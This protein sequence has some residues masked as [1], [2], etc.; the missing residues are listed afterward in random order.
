MIRRETRKRISAVSTLQPSSARLIPSTLLMIIDRLSENTNL[1]PWSGP[2]QDKHAYVHRSSTRLLCW[3]SF[4]HQPPPGPGAASAIASFPGSP[5][6][7]TPKARASIKALLDEGESPADA[8]TW[9]D[10]NRRRLPKTAPWHYVDVP[11]DEP[12]YDKKW[13]AD[14]PK[15][16]RAVDKSIAYPDA[17]GCTSISIR[18]PGRQTQFQVFPVPTGS[19]LGRSR[20]P[21]NAARLRF[22]RT[23]RCSASLATTSWLRLTPSASA[24]LASAAWSDLGTRTL[25]L[26]LYSR[27]S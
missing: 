27:R 19:K 21:G 1:E 20:D 12:Q 26:P 16:G 15:K 10:E 23:R 8:S 14:D 18:C 3:S 11:L 22:Q 6:H 13:S 2:C 7:M 25:N 5:Q 17:S 24:S 9:A 4:S